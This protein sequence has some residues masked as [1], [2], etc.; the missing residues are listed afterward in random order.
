M[1]RASRLVRDA[2]A[3]VSR[4]HRA[5]VPASAPSTSAPSRALDRPD[6]SPSR[7]SSP[8]RALF[9]SARAAMGKTKRRHPSHAPVRAEELRYDRVVAVEDASR[10]LEPEE[11]TLY[12]TPPKTWV[13][14]RR[15]VGRRAGESGG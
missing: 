8:S 13:E 14:R 11:G 12:G 7:A 9:A 6:A 2:L 15:V 4:E 3:R 5:R 10:A 1:R